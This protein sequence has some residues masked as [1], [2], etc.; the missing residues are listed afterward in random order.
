MSNKRIDAEDNTKSHNR[1]EF[2][3]RATYAAPVL[4]SLDAAPAFAQQGSAAGGG[5]MDPEPPVDTG[6]RPRSAFSCD[7]PMQPI[8]SDVAVSTCEITSAPD[9]TALFQDVIITPEQ[10]PGSVAQGN[11]LDTC[12]N[13]ICN[14]S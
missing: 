10:V 13:F 3:R 8:D 12:D 7:D 1:R 11:V 2:L 4:L 5:G 9:G 6:P 14:A